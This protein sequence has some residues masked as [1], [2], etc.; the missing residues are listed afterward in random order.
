M[1]TSPLAAANAYS[2]IQTTRQPESLP[3]SPNGGVVQLSILDDLPG[4]E[5]RD[6]ELRARSYLSRLSS[7]CRTGTADLRE[8]LETTRVLARLRN[9][10]DLERLASFSLGLLSMDEGLWSAAAEHFRSATLTG[11]SRTETAC[12]LYCRAR[13]VIEISP[14]EAALS[15]CAGALRL[16]R[17]R[18]GAAV[19]I[20]I[21]LL[22]VRVYREM[23]DRARAWRCCDRIRETPGIASDVDLMA[24]VRIAEAELLHETGRQ[25]A[26]EN[27]CR[28]AFET[29]DNAG[30][31]GQA[32]GVGIVSILR[33]WSELLVDLSRGREARRKIDT[34]FEL[35][36]GRIDEEAGR[37]HG[38]LAVL[39]ME[40]GDETSAWESLRMGEHH[41]RAARSRRFLA[42]LLLLRGECAVL[43]M[44]DSDERS[45]ARE[46]VIEARVLFRR[47]G[48]LESVKRCDLFLETFRF[49]P[50]GGNGSNERRLTAP[51][52]PRV[53]RMR[54]LSQLGFLTSDVRILRALEPLESMARSSI[55]VLILG[56]SGTGKEVLARALHRAA[57]GRG[58]FVAVNCGALPSELQESELFGHVRGAF[59]GAVAD[60]TGL[61]EAADGGTLLLDEVGEMSLRAQVK[62]LRILELGEVRRVGETR[63]RRVRVRVLA[64]TN[65]DLKSQIE[66]G[67]FRR[68]LY[69]RLCGLGV[70]LPP[71]RERLGDVPLLSTHFAELFS[72]SVDSPPSLSPEALDR[73]LQHSW[74]G[75]VRELRFAMEKAVVLT[76]ALNR[77]RI[78]ADC[79]D[80]EEV[81][82]A[83]PPEK[84][85]PSGDELVA[86]GGLEAYI[87]NTERRLILKALEENEWNRT[88]AARSLGG[89]S[90][91]TLIGKMK[92]LGLF[93]GP[94]KGRCGEGEV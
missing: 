27:A 42:E 46:G 13:S 81:N 83:A 29:L 63:T 84:P 74:P 59:T 21:R 39:D 68:D 56:E 61:F 25:R 75:N 53:P 16:A 9:R 51:N 38:L 60:K 62:L 85:S 34:A 57:G 17:S 71:L 79:I 4:C 58:P 2:P 82:V 67:A 24:A 32:S 91:T 7:V 10:A 8:R 15:I 64:A 73:L 87:E 66:R 88:R 49:S 93:P 31:N 30:Q 52:L 23:G 11:G 12:C 48:R 50:N 41:L 76:N 47:I 14:P 70:T 26:A 22:A 78:E 43:R 44:T 90:R 33:K 28:E 86:S 3:T 80:V 37:L 54:R 89:M 65:A 18:D 19:R 5:P 69:F 55:P 94:G 92:R 6:L 1:S 20:R 36:G 40:E 77:S 72:E 45:A 35:L